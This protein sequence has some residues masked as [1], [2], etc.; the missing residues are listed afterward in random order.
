[1]KKVSIVYHSGMGHTKKMAESVLKGA[2]SVKDTKSVLLEIKGDDIEKGRYQNEELMK[3]ALVQL[4][5]EWESK[6]TNYEKAE[7]FLKMAWQEYCDIIVFPEMFNTG[8]SMN[9]SSIAEDEGGK[10]A[11]I[12]SRMAKKYNIN[13]IAGFP[14]KAIDEKKGRN[15]AVVYN[16]KGELIAKFT[17]LHPFS[18][19]DE[20]K[21]YIPGTNTVIF[22]IEGMPS[23]IFIRA[24]PISRLVILRR[25]ARW[26]NRAA[27]WTCSRC[28][29]TSSAPFWWV[30]PW[31]S[32]VLSATQA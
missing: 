23:S 31:N 15:I 1:M 21:Y 2:G 30:M 19:S 17:K 20:D 16:R 12:L 22:D 13:L 25:S 14:A 29:T 10:T 18:F 6:K 24:P 9:V 27:P 28:A 8:F 26:W 7:V 32:A 5:I 4:E 3:I 11:L